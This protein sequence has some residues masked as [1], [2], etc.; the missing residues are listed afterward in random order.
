M[1]SF[2]ILQFWLCRENSINRN[3]LINEV[4]LIC[5]STLVH[6]VKG[7][8]YKFQ[9]LLILI[10]S[11]HEWILQKTNFELKMRFY[12]GTCVR[13]YVFVFLDCFSLQHSIHKTNGWIHFN[14]LLLNELNG[15]WPFDKFTTWVHKYLVISEF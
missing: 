5:R 14:H 2:I 12:W 6:L 8:L 15:D 3:Y 11:R 9:L 7:S 1:R 10:F 13:V 4:V